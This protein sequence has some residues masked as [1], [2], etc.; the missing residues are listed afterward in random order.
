VAEYRA[1]PLVHDRISSRLFTEWVAASEAAVGRAG[2]LEARCL[3]VLSED[4]RIIDRE[5]GLEFARRAG[6]LATVRTYPGRYHEPFNDL[7]ANEV[8][9]DL[10]AW[11]LA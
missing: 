3:V 2:E 10:A 5:G 11:L 8:F 7:D 9:A 1:D 4:D 6:D